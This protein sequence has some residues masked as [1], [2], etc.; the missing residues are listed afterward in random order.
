MSSKFEISIRLRNFLMRTSLMQQSRIHSMK[1]KDS[2]AKPNITRER[3]GHKG[4]EQR[5][6]EK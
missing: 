3:Q 4:D 1:M 2:G 6:S 5:Y